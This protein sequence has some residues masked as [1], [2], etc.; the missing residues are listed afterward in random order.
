MS[1]AELWWLFAAMGAV[2]LALRASFLLA[3]DRVSLPAYVNRALAFVPPA[4][5]AA[6]VAPALF[7]PGGA[8]L[9]PLNARLVAG[10]VAIGVA[11]RTKSVLAT[12]IVGMATLWALTWIF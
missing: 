2:T 3:Q 6:I 8:Q 11:W 9:G 12:I 5:L 1:G 4:V 10:L 7:E